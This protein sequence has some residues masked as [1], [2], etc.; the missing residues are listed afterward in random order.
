[1]DSEGSASD[2]ESCDGDVQWT[3]QQVQ[4]VFFLSFSSSVCDLQAGDR[5]LWKCRGQSA[6]LDSVEM[7]VA[8]GQSTDRRRGGRERAPCGKKK[9]LKNRALSFVCVW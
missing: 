2:A 8:F 7:R 9:S 6:R 3:R 4:K 1:M 5:A